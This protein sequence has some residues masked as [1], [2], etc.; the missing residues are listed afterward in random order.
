MFQEV[1][2]KAVTQRLTGSVLGKP[3]ALDRLFY[4]FLQNG[5]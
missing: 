1:G 3:S 4:Y 5:G 2:R